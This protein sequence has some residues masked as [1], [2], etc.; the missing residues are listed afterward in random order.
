M[1]VDYIDDGLTV[2]DW[3]NEDIRAALKT[4]RRFPGDRA[5]RE[6]LQRLL[7]KRRRY[8]S[9]EPMTVYLMDVGEGNQWF[10]S[11]EDV[12][13]W[14]DNAEPDTPYT[15]ETGTMTGREFGNLR[16]SGY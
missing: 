1:M 8:R 11:M 7:E 5:C 16:C 13:S 2:N 4:C 15:Y 6:R 10:E 3:N 12:Q 14:L 9:D